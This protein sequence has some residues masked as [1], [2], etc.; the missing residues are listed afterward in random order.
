MT[1]SPDLCLQSGPSPQSVFV[2]A[3]P[4]PSSGSQDVQLPSLGLCA[5]HVPVSFYIQILYQC[6][7]I[8]LLYSKLPVGF[9][10]VGIAKI[11]ITLISFGTAVSHTPHLSKCAPG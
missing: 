7:E 6:L 9:L 1:P 5:T 11:V 8:D 10:L 2:P 4:A 3:T